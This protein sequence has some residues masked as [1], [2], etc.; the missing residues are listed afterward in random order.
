[1]P[2]THFNPAQRH[3]WH[4]LATQKAFWGEGQPFLASLA[5]PVPKSWPPLPTSPLDPPDFPPGLRVSCLPFTFH[6]QAPSPQTC[7]LEHSHPGDQGQPLCSE[8]FGMYCLGC[9]LQ[10][11]QTFP[12]LF[13]FKHNQGLCDIS[14]PLPTCFHQTPRPHIS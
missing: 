9:Y 1:M 6:T 14:H 4:L 10:I 5:H 12:C 8:F 13:K 11:L 3:I 2:D 7:Y